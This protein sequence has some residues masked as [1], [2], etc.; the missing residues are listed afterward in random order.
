MLPSVS[1]VLV[2]DVAQLGV[3]NAAQVGESHRAT[4]SGENMNGSACTVPL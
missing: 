4:S 2:M 3:Q 1:V